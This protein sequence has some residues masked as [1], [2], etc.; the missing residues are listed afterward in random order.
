MYSKLTRRLANIPHAC[1]AFAVCPWLLPHDLKCLQSWTRLACAQVPVIGGKLACRDDQQALPSPCLLPFVPQAEL[2]PD[3][4]QPGMS[5]GGTSWGEVALRCAQQV[6]SAEDKSNLELYLFR[7]IVPSKKLDI[8]LDKLDDVYGSPSIDDISTFSRA[9][10]AGGPRSLVPN[11]RGVARTWLLRLHRNLLLCIC[12]EHIPPAHCA[13][14]MS[15]CS[16][17][18]REHWSSTRSPVISFCRAMLSFIHA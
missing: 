8:R 2:E 16:D 6:L 13:C 17:T 15:L 3:D 4:V 5:T 12:F 1:S 14:P 10:F 7:A 11:L 9:L 18:V